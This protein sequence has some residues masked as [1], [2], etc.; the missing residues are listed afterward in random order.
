MTQPDQAGIPDQK[1]EQVEYVDSQ[2]HKEEDLHTQEPLLILKIR[3]GRKKTERFY[4]IIWEEEFGQ[5]ILLIMVQIIGQVPKP[6]AMF[7]KLS[8]RSS[9]SPNL[10]SV[11][12]STLLVVPG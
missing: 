6:E 1:K 10:K 5:V 2:Y 11:A 9:P 8:S 3:E 7:P 4:I 12:I